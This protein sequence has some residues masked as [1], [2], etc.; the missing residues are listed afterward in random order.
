MRSRLCVLS[1]PRFVTFNIN[2]RLKG[3]N[4]P[5]PGATLH[6]KGTPLDAIVQT[7]QRAQALGWNPQWPSGYPA[8]RDMK[9][10][11]GLFISFF[12]LF[13]TVDVPCSLSKKKT[14]QTCYS[15]CQC[16]AHVHQ[17]TMQCTMQYTWQSMDV[18]LW[19]P[20]VPVFDQVRFVRAHAGVYGIDTSKLAVT[21][22]SA[23]ATNAVA[24]GVTFDS[25]YKSELNATQDPTLAT[26]FLNESSTVQAVYV[27][28]SFQYINLYARA[29]FISTSTHVYLGTV[30]LAVGLVD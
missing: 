24:T 12:G 21:G 20:S 14:P 27:I 17:Y 22:G 5:Y 26:T 9:A 8:V 18:S 1:D 13:C 19:F 4:G 6:F 11:V 16:S 15:C 2:Y 30:D 3:D 7:T 10:A 23:G 25:D 29:V 28:Y